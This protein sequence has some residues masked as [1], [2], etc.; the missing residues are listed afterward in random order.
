MNIDL[1]C[2]MGELSDSAHEA[3]LMQYISSANIAC[4]A[5]A[6]DDAIMERTARLA[7]ERGV[8]IG[9]HPGY[10]DRENFGRIPMPMTAA[11]IE[12]AVYD[13]IV[14][15]D[16]IVRRLGGAIVHVKPHGALYNV[17][18]KDAEVAR[19]IGSGVARW[20]PR[21][22]IFGLAGSPMLEVWR[23]MNL[24]VAA[25]AFA[26]RCYEPDG[27][28]RSRKLPGALITDPASAAAQAVRL[29]NEGKAQTICV[30]GDTPGAVEILKACA[31][32]LARNS[33][34]IQP[35][36]VRAAAER[37]RPLARRTPVLTSPAFDEAAG[38]RVFFKCE[39]LQRGGA[40]KIRGA[41][42]MVLSLPKE[43]LAKG[44]VSYSSGNHAQAVAIASKHV[45]AQCTIV[46][47]EDAP[48]SKMEATRSHG[49]RIVAYNRFTESREA[50][51]AAILK[52]TGA[53]LVPP[54]D[55]PLIMAGQGTAAMELLEET[56]PLDAIMTPTGGGGLL[57]GSATIAK[58]LYPAIRVFGA[59]PEGANDTY[60]SM[61]AGE[62]V[63]VA[64]PNTIADGLRSPRPGDLTFPVLRRLV[65]SIL[66][67]TDDE[68]RA[69]VKFLL[70]HL[71]ILAEPSGAVPV[72]AALFHK[73]PADVRSIG[74]VISGGNV[75][76]E[77]LAKY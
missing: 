18:V 34:A 17:A 12:Q 68:I 13:Q 20:N 44:I 38:L 39:N 62:P 19:A 23:G 57:S 61:A 6:G 51:A 54:F 72:A 73:L 65:E 69:A 1:N 58:D 47:P 7:L 42:N 48:R 50:L 41:S 52:E 26:D 25:E 14:R 28:L 31:Q 56:G 46:M 21:V 22:P 60:L 29:A 2:D 27:T 8:R 36:D 55:H 33:L 35:D 24:P 9:A 3:A 40:F 32:A 63:T 45:G 77:D 76:F 67:V 71:K 64:H 70:L 30:H 5:H 37:I 16:A 75:D 43:A 15:L 11:E 4:G 59:E 66:L 49:A 10:P 53:T 74:I